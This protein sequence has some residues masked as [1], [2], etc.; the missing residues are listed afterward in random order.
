MT[1]KSCT[2][3]GE[4]KPLTPEFFNKK[5]DGFHSKCRP[6]RNE[7]RRRDWSINSV[8]INAK[9]RQD[10][11]ENG[12]VIRAH[13]RHR[14]QTSPAKKQACADWKKRNPERVSEINA[15]SYR[16][17]PSKKKAQAK[18]WARNNPQKRKQIARNLHRRRMASDPRYRITRS[19]RAYLT[20]Q[21]RE[22][23][24]GRK[25][26]SML[27]YSIGDLMGHLE[28]QFTKGMTWDN[29]GDWHID[30]IVPVSSFSIESADDPNLVRCW[31]LS[32]LRP[33]WASENIAKS[34]KRL[35][36]V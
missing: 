7:Q 28:R 29:Y 16:L 12:E 25:T 17:N 13:D 30:H 15:K 31:S 21:L 3:C 22:G 10:R 4:S 36:L 14:Y 27:G 23:K 34:D 26:E 11:I 20:W 2:K 32:N 35:F 19:I 24:A 1:L 18:E 33:C 9:R 8:E 6:C 5:R